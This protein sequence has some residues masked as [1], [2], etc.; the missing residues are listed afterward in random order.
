MRL[1]GA[2]VDLQAA[3]EGFTA[4]I[5]QLRKMGDPFILAQP[6]PELAEF[7]VAHGRVSEADPLLAEARGIFERLGARPWLERIERIQ[8]TV[9]RVASGV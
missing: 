9:P 3:E 5:E 8:R 2:V 4:A 6:L 7:L 1:D